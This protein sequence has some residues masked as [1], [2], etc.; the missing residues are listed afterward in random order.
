VQLDTDSIANPPKEPHA[1]QRI[2]TSHH[3]PI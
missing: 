1:D 2:V 3:P